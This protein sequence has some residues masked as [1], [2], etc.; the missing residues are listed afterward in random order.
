MERSQAGRTG[1]R[2]TDRGR[3]GPRAA[4]QPGPSLPAP[5]SASFL[6]GCH[7][8]RMSACT[9]S[10]ECSLAHVADVSAKVAMCGKELWTG[11]VLAV[12]AMMVDPG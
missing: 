10:C 7:Q 8:L 12:F 5:S 11:P 6:Q 1:F 3:C 2:Q 9:C 4:G